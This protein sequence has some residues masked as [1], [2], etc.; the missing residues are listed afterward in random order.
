MSNQM[1]TPGI[2]C[3]D[4]VDELEANFLTYAEYVIKDRAIPDARDG[5]KPVQRRILY[6]MWEM[7]CKSNTTF[8]KSARV[9]G[10]TIGKFHPHG[11]TSAYGAMVRMA[12]PFSMRHPLIEGQGNFGSVDTPESFAAMRYTESRLSKFSEVALFA[13][14]NDDVVDMVDNYTGEFREPTV[15]PARVPLLLL[16]GVSGISVGM[17][18]SVPPFSLAEVCLAME[19][20]LGDPSVPIE[21]I[22]K[23]VRG[24]DFPT[25]GII[26]SGTSLYSTLGDGNGSFRFRVTAQSETEG[27][28]QSLI[29][30]C[31]PYSKSK[32]DIIRS[33]AECVRDG[34]IEGISDVNDDSAKSEI[35]IR[36]DLKRGVSSKAVLNNLYKQRSIGLQ[37][38]YSVNLVSIVNRKPKQIG[39]IDVLAHFIEFRRQIVTRRIQNQK[40]QA[41]DRLEL[42]NGMLKAIH[43]SDKV[44]NIVKVSG[45]AVTEL[46]SLL[47]FTPR[48]ADYVFNMPLRRFSKADKGKLNDEKIDREEFI[49][50]AAE[51]LVDRSKVDGI[52]LEETQSIRQQFSEPRLTTVVKDFDTIELEDTIKK[53]DV[54]LVFMSDGTV[55]S[56]PV[57]N[58]RLQKRNGKGMM[59]VKVPDGVHTI[60][61]TNVNSHDHVILITEQ[62]NRYRMRAFDVPAEN[63]GRKPR[64]VGDYVSLFQPGEHIVG[65]TPGNLNDDECLLLLSEQGLL[66]KQLGDTVNNSRDSTTSIYP[67]TDGGKVV[68]AVTAKVDDEIIVATSGGRVLRTSLTNIR[69][70]Q[71]RSGRGVKIMNIQDDERILSVCVVKPNGDLLTV[72]KQGYAKRT[73][74]TEYS[75]K[76]RG[77]KGVQGCKLP[78]DDELVYAASTSGV[79]EDDNL[80]VL[81]NLNKAMRT[82]IVE[83]RVLQ[84]RAG[85]GTVVKKM[86]EGEHVVSVSIE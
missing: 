3:A 73:P 74:Y 66:K 61:A 33:I 70:V 62:G 44:I 59:G 8:K 20:I 84:G 2:R 60:F 76:G 7:G 5:L 85:R 58:Y 16:T 11:D 36:I 47:G 13:D 29:V 64:S 82:R 56:T 65:V 68:S 24:P 17:A 32:T 77:G 31:I 38:N 81:S 75:A 34:K 78:D 6:A 53:Q 26:T 27:E 18:T 51:V 21:E 41:E 1:T 40:A 22:A 86:E 9:I 12:Q 28:S 15:L 10:N 79:D 49:R 69:E 42:V 67:V 46:Q 71:S 54:V 48:Q 39:I 4:I 43:H 14:I 23:I 83:I 30:S 57:A 45:D 35:R 52:I 72:S 55:K 50:N 37:T 80:F 19:R 63:R 25:G